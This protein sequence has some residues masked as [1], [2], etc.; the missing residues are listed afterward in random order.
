MTKIIPLNPEVTVTFMAIN[1]ETWVPIKDI[2]AAVQAQ[3]D[4]IPEEVNAVEAGAIGALKT[5]LYII[6]NLPT[7]PTN[8]Q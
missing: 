3:L 5:V 4:A 7:K 6:D 1:G 8:R 2:R